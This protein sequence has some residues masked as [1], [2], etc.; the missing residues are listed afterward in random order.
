MICIKLS[1]IT[2]G[3]GQPLWMATHPSD[4]GDS[5]NQRRRGGKWNT[6][7]MMFVGGVLLI[8]DSTFRTFPIGNL[9]QGGS[10]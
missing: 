4:W 1:I 3:L 9:L 2:L 8:V 5:L 6:M 7:V 10:I